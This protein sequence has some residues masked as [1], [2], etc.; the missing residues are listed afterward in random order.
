MKY[1]SNALLAVVAALLI[2]YAIGR[3]Y[4]KKKTLSGIAVMK[5]IFVKKG[6]EN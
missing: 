6:V 1:I 3:I 2:N 5:G 4:I